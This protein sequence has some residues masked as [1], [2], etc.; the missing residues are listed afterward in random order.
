MYICVLLSP[1]P[2]YETL[3]IL[4]ACTAP[5]LP[6]EDILMPPSIKVQP[7]RTEITMGRHKTLKAQVWLIWGLGEGVSQQGLN[8]HQRRRNQPW[9]QEML[10]D[11]T[12]QSRKSLSKSQREEPEV[13]SK[14]P[15]NVP[16]SCTS[17]RAV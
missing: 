8:R 11:A 5:F 14:P 3:S 7:N 4:Y 13:Q 15:V 12:S 1:R 16:S 9:G 2:H 6:M 10:G 17:P